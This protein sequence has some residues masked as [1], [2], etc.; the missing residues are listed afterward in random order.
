MGNILINYL[1]KRVTRTNQHGNVGKASGPVITI[2]REVGCSGLELACELKNRLNK[3]GLQE[4]WKVLSK[5]IFQKSAQELDLE[6]ENVAKIFKQSDR[7]AFDDILY[8]FREKR[9]ISEKKVR[10]TVIDI[11]RSFAEDGHCIIVGRAG[12]LISA[13]IKN[14]LHIRLV[15]PPEYRIKSIMQKNSLDYNEAVRFIAGEEKD[16]MAYRKA[17]MEKQ[18]DQPEIFDLTFNRAHF[19]TENIADIIMYVIEK[20]G[21]LNDYRSRIGYF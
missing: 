14:S 12:N 4:T 5:E 7:N 16:R 9:S 15:A 2:S 3:S 6:P 21:I 11:I 17:V 19:S 13:D 1:N 10:H 20:K 18:T 8:T